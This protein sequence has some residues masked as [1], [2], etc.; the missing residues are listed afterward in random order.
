MQQEFEIRISGSGTP[1]EIV[2]ALKSIIE[3]IEEA[4]KSENTE[5][6]LDGADWES[7]TLMTEI[8]SL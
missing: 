7:E 2:S 6:I 3:A 5:A 1:K 8:D 4:I